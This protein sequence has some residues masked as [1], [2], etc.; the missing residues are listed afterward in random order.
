MVEEMASPSPSQKR[1]WSQSRSLMSTTTSSC[2]GRWTTSSP[3]SIRSLILPP[4]DPSILIHI[5][6]EVSAQ[7]SNPLAHA[8]TH[9]I[10]NNRQ[11]GEE[12]ETMSLSHF[13]TV[14]GGMERSKQVADWLWSARMLVRIEGC[15]Q[16]QLSKPCPVRCLNVRAGIAAAAA[17]AAGR[18]RIPSFPDGSD[19]R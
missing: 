6:C 11:K 5:K 4:P 8:Y 12:E 13:T 17:A 15:L 1:I 16:L 10:D 2:P 7:L 18:S 19:I 14:K 9:A 3:S